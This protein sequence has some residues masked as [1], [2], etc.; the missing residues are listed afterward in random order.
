MN[1][2]CDE[3]DCE[4]GAICGLNGKQYCMIHFTEHIAEIGSTLRGLEEISSLLRER[5]DE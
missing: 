2:V 1:P 5:E 4:A 3:P